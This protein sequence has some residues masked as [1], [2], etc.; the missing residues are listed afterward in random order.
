[1]L[2]GKINH[3]CKCHYF[4]ILKFTSN[5]RHHLILDDLTS[6]YISLQQYAHH[7]YHLSICFLLC[8]EIHTNF[9]ENQVFPHVDLVSYSKK[10][11]AENGCFVKYFGK[12]V[13]YY[14]W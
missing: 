2:I 9:I 13:L 12:N 7:R 3:I 1:M 4:I 11:Y 14:I 8:S 10:Y 5:P 6:Y